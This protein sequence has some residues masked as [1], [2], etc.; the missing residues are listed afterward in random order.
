MIGDFGKSLDSILELSSNLHHF[1]KNLY[2]N[3]LQDLGSS[4]VS[5]RYFSKNNTCTW[6]LLFNVYQLHSGDEQLRIDSYGQVG[7]GRSRNVWAHPQCLF[8]PCRRV[9]HV[10]EYYSLFNSLKIH[11]KNM[12]GYP[13]LEEYELCT[14]LL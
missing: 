3:L 13:F 4:P 1:L 12:Y 9:I 11:L 2:Q 6:V 14:V 8:D 5:I 10:F 7:L